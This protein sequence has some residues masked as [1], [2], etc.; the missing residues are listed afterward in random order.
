MTSVALAQP[1]SPEFS[2]AY[3]QLEQDWW[4]FTARRDL[5]SRLC[6]GWLNGQ[7]RV[8]ELGCGSGINATLFPERCAYV[9]V[10]ISLPSLKYGTAHG[11]R[12]LCLATLDRLPFASNSFDLVLL[13][14]VLEHLENEAP[15]LEETHRVLR[16]GGEA[17]VLSPAHMCLWGAHDVVNGHKRRYCERQLQ[18][19]LFSHRFEV[20]KVAYWDFL[21]FPV[22]A[23]VRWQDRRRGLG[24]KP[25][26]DFRQLP[27]W[28]NR[29]LHR[30][31]QLEGRLVCQGVRLPTGTSLLV[32]ARKGRMR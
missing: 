16:T 24:N 10:D 11:S 23:L 27:G 22:A 2:Q 20:E 12:S 32:T 29:V 26:G 15:A 19:L 1:W 31:L 6:N 21:G 8:L 18:G 14:D 28:L 17:L 9:G 4:W 3:W 5:V 30:A 13:L 7:A 25:T